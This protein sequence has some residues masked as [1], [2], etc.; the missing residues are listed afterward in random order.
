MMNPDWVYRPPFADGGG[1]VIDSQPPFGVLSSFTSPPSIDLIWDDQE[2]KVS[3][4]LLFPKK[5]YG[6]VWLS[7]FD[8]DEDENGVSSSHT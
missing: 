1:A 6:S 3:S 2:T 4:P 8:V 7:L 5:R